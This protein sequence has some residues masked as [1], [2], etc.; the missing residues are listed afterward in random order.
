LP[1]SPA[2][3]AAP[4][5]GKAAAA[6]A[7]ATAACRRLRNRR[8]QRA[9]EALQATGEDRRIERASALVPARDR[10]ARVDAL[11]RL[12]PAVDA[13]EDDGVGQ[14][15]GEDLRLFRERLPILLRARHVEA[16]SQRLS[17]EIGAQP[18]PARHP[19]VGDDHPAAD[20]DDG[21]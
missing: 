17:E 12:R 9:R 14:V 19:A 4:A 20:Q 21:D 7:T 3:A 6:A 2:T 13:A 8:A 10:G 15:L 11:E 18:G 1:G 16:E 5:A